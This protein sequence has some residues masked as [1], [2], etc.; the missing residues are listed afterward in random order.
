MISPVSRRWPILSRRLC[1]LCEMRSA[2]NLCVSGAGAETPILSETPS[3]GVIKHCDF[4]ID[5]KYARWRAHASRFQQFCAFWY[6]LI[7]PFLML[8]ANEC[9]KSMF[10]GCS[11]RFW[12]FCDATVI[13]LLSAGTPVQPMFACEDCLE[14]KCSTSLASVYFSSDISNDASAAGACDERIM[15]VSSLSFFHASSILFRSWRMVIMLALV[16]DCFV[17]DGL[18]KTAKASLAARL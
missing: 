1:W 18:L 14:W 5:W 13:S 7:C 17:V 8:W 3:G 11:R 2:Y 15:G 12:G 10:S 9:C 4:E 16:A 6:D